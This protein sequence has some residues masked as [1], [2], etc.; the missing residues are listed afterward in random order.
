MTDDF[1]VFRWFQ[2]LWFRKSRG[3]KQITRAQSFI[4]YRKLRLYIQHS[5]RTCSPLTTLIYSFYRRMTP[6]RGT[7]NF[8]ADKNA[9]AVYAYAI[10]CRAGHNPIHEST[11]TSN[12][13]HFSCIECIIHQFM[14]WNCNLLLTEFWR[15]RAIRF[16][17]RFFCLL[18]YAS[19]GISTLWS[20]LQ[21]YAYRRFSS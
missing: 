9:H 21:L 8:I 2:K 18:K 19:D 1:F 5:V 14:L 7:L 10:C 3:R 6:H 11:F 13:Q 4:N 20:F 16:I 12:S 15:L 17:R